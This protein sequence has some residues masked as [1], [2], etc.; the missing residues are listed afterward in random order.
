MRNQHKW[1]NPLLKLYN[2]VHCMIIVNEDVIKGRANSTL[3]RVVDIKSNTNKSLRWKSYHG[4]VYT[5]NVSAIEYVGFEYYPQK[6]NK[7]NKKIRFLIWQKS[8]GLI[9]WAMK[10][11]HNN[12]LCWQ[13]EELLYDHWDLGWHQS[14]SIVIF[15]FVEVI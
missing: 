14:C 9:L 10:N 8:T 12:T 13:N 7:S 4:K 3:F 2:G 11:P 6:S 1:I 15:N 5:T